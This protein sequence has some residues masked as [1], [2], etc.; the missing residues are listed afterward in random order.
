MVLGDNEL[1]TN[2]AVLKNMTDGSKT[3]VELGE[4][5][6]EEIYRHKI[7]RELADCVNGLSDGGE[8]EA[9]AALLGGL[10]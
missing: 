2:K 1:D 4:K 8:A 9:M 3:E 6:I 7:D 5:L 10:K